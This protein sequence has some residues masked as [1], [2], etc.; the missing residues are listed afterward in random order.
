[1]RD[2]IFPLR[3]SLG[4]YLQFLGRLQGV[5]SICLGLSVTV[6]VEALTK[7]SDKFLFRLSPKIMV[8]STK[9]RVPL[10]FPRICQ[11]DMKSSTLIP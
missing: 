2:R 8:F 3:L 5:F 4:Q 9:C 10:D 6:R 7:L 11:F 1:M